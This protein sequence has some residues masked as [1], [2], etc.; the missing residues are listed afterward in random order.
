MRS[1]L[2]RNTPQWINPNTLSDNVFVFNFIQHKVKCE[3]EWRLCF[4]HLPS[5]AW[6]PAFTSVCMC[7][8]SWIKI[9]QHFVRILI[10][11]FFFFYYCYFFFFVFRFCLTFWHNCYQCWK[12]NLR[13]KIEY[14]KYY[15]IMLTTNFRLRNYGKKIISDL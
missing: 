8:I 13:T 1:L 7:V 4:N 3:G 9:L 14:C 11:W 12:R 6:L 5:K 2:L 15:F 10:C